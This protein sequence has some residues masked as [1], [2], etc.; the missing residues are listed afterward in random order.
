MKYS[1]KKVTEGKVRKIYVINVLSHNCGK[2]TNQPIAP[3]PGLLGFFLDFFFLRG[4]KQGHV[5][6]TEN[7]EW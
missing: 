1:K 2:N 4:K 3:H 7:N 6:T 5:C